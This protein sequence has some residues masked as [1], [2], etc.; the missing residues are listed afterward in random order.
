MFGWLGGIET[1]RWK[2]LHGATTQAQAVVTAARLN[3]ARGAFGGPPYQVRYQFR[4]APSGASFGY[5]GQALLLERWAR[6][7]RNV[8][9]AAEATM[10]MPVRYAPS[11]PRINQPSELPLPGLF[12]AIGF[13]VFA[14]LAIIGS[15][16]V[17]LSSPP[18][19]MK[20]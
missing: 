1:Y 15:V 19:P 3:P 14:A 9:T 7:P 20:R 6:V 10:R 18:P 8:F 13:F 16:V 12:D 17:A 11:D 5:T 4:A 2:L